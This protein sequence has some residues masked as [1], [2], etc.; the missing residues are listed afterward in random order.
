MK[1]NLKRDLEVASTAAANAEERFRLLVESVKDYGIFMLDIEGY[2]ESWN[3]G[4]ERITGYTASEVIGQHFSLFYTE[5]DMK[6][7]HPQNE[8][9]IAMN[10]GRYEEEGW[11]VRKNGTRFW[12]SVV[13]T[14]LRDHHSQELVGFAKVVRDLSD[15][16]ATEEKLRLSEER[17]RKMFEGV[18][19]YALITLTPEGKVATWN[20]GARRIKGYEANEIIGKYFATF[21]PEQDVQM[22]KCEYE[23]KE[24]AETGRFE[25]EGW[26]VRKDGTKFWASVIITAIRGEKGEL[27]GYSKVTRDITDRKRADDLL[28]MAYSNLEK[29]VDERTRELTTAN[30]KLQEAIRVR[31][32]FLS[33]ASHELRTP[34]TPLKLQIQGLVS[35]I[36]RKQLASLTEDRLRKMADISDKSIN[37][38]STLIDNLLDISRI[39]TG[40]LQLNYEEV[41]VVEMM[42]ELVERYKTEI[43]NSGCEVAIKSDGVVVGMFDRLRLEQ[44]I[45]NLLTN[46]LKY[47]AGKPI[48]V[49]LTTIADK[50]IITFKDYGIGI[51]KVDQERIFQRFEQVENKTQVGGLGLGLYITRQII[52]AHGGKISLESNLGE[53]TTFMIQL[54]LKGRR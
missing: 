37:R 38:L 44:I 46:S 41:N 45:L 2:I 1:Q 12:A 3:D 42:Q 21:Y 22:G 16:K 13:I 5:E 52:E 36:R 33:I 51:A 50:V 20:E 35:L 8:I 49:S 10:N 25:D 19:D 43:L 29:R 11:R 48:D 15:R 17:T 27:L 39:N 40:K 14:A 23:L 54:P 9:G 32:E 34:L 6:R 24:A 4:G 30:T 31:D 53:G 47:G 18:K 7:S 28:K 26:R